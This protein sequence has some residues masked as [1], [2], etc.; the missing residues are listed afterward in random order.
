MYLSSV[1]LVDFR[2]WPSLHVEMG[3]GVT[4]FIGSNGQGKTNI[5]EAIC[6][7]AT[8]SSHRVSTDAPLIRE[9]KTAAKI[10]THAVNNQR[11]LTTHLLINQGKANQ[12]QINRARCKTPRELLGI[13]KT[14]LFAP[15]DLALVRGEPAQRRR[16]LD[17]IIAYRR[18]QFLAIKAEYE[19]I[20]R[21]RNAVL[22]ARVALDTLDI[23]DAQLAHTG[24][25]LMAFR[26]HLTHELAP[27]ISQA[28]RELAPESR[29]AT[30][31]YRPTVE[32][33]YSEDLDNEYLRSIESLLLEALKENRQKEVDRGQSLIGP[34]R[35][36]LELILGSQPAKGFASHGETWSFALALKIATFYLL[37]E[38]GT[39]PIL[40]LDDVFAELD[41]KRRQ[42]LTTIIATAEQ[43]LITAAVNEDLPE[44]FLNQATIHHVRAIPDPEGDEHA[45]V[46]LLDS[47]QSNE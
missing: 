23:W 4:A 39:D 7:T 44:E 8:L 32:I 21:Q 35:D 5:V 25:I 13:V 26:R 6:Y 2:S 18:P 31:E 14:V 42:A 15:E 17:E 10:S 22:K 16:Y 45:R 29:P 28:Y 40:I 30:V 3:Q 36:D 41:A 9:G 11:E 38:D 24:A 12:A 47:E 34:H 46:S 1:D 37:R 27:F 33:P 20:I 43:V 19:K